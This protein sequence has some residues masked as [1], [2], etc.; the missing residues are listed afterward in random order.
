ML[1]P[2]LS[3][4]VKACV[5]SVTNTNAVFE[6]SV[7]AGFVLLECFVPSSCVA[8]HNSFNSQIILAPLLLWIKHTCAWV[9][10]QQFK[11]PRFSRGPAAN[12]DQTCRYHVANRHLDEDLSSTSAP[13]SIIL[14][15]A[16]L[17]QHQCLNVSEY[18]IVGY[19]SWQEIVRE[20]LVLPWAEISQNRQ[21]SPNV[22]AG[23]Q[24]SDLRATR[25]DEA[26]RDSE[27]GD[28]QTDGTRQD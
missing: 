21:T 19:S 13:P 14:S 27:G 26:R 24:K 4:T 1:R 6:K 20:I 25:R 7:L 15:F 22:Q 16:V 12:C 23:Y 3:T 2:S 9:Q 8:Q 18:F 17:P 10:W 11:R 5:V 28:A